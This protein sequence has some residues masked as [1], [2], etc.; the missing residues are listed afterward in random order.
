LSAH[1]KKQR[2]YYSGKKKRHT[3]KTQL[4][5]SKNSMEI[6]A[7]EV[8]NG[9]VHDF[10]I[11]KESGVHILAEN[12]VIVDSGYQGSQKIHANTQLPKKRKKKQKLSKEDKQA[13]KKLASDRVMNEH[14]NG[15]L[16]RFKIFAEKYRN[17]RK[18]FGL[19]I[20]L[21][22]GIYNLELSN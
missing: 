9:K 18:R 1:K 16:K 10:R 19:R 4:V 2:K 12:H 14:V 22:A 15:L 3:L 20:N 21:L 11:F 8:R 7:V 6:L 17:R 5:V 13:N